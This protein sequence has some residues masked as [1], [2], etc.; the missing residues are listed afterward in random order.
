MSIIDFSYGKRCPPSDTHNHIDFIVLC[1]LI[2]IV[3]S[4]KALL[5]TINNA[6]LN[7]NK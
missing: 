7:V 3:V 6:I 4:R 2:V 1:C 5:T